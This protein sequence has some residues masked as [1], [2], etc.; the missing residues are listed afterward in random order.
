MGRLKRWIRR[1]NNGHNSKDLRPVG[2]RSVTSFQYDEDFAAT[3][4]DL[5]NALDLATL[6]TVTATRSDPPD[7]LDL[8]TLP[9]DAATRLGLPSALD[10]ATLSTVSSPWQPFPSFKEREHTS[11]LED[12]KKFCSFFPQ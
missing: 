4:I 5:P 12:L 2:Y 1:L 6:S 8:A 3:R 9:T 10:L 7:A 11:N